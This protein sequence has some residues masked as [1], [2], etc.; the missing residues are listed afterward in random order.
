MTP[1]SNEPP[2]AREMDEWT[3][4]SPAE[5]L[6]SLLSDADAAI[7]KGT[8]LLRDAEHYDLAAAYV[9]ARVSIVECR[10][11]AP[12]AAPAGPWMVERDVRYFGDRTANIYRVHWSS[13]VAFETEEI[14]EA[15]AVRDALNR[16]VS[17]VPEY[18]EPK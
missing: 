7:G 12:A 10:G 14:A 1:R 3:R 13:R 18:G 5:Y 6:A 15:T 8:T 17:G 11:L 16:V 2:T 4:E 9:L